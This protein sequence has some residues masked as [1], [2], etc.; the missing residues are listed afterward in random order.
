[1]R[2]MMSWPGTSAGC[3]RPG[4]DEQRRTLRMGDDAVQPFEVLEQ[5]ARALVR[6]EAA[7]EADREDVGILR[8]RVAQHAIEM[9]LA[10]AIAQV[11]VPDASAHHVEHPALE[12]A[13]HGPEQVVGNA[14]D[15]RERAAVGEMLGP[16]RTDEAL[17]QVGPLGRHERAVV[18]RVR[19]VIDRILG[20]RHLRPQ[21]LQHR[22][23]NAAVN[24]GHAVVEARSAY[25]ER[26][27]V[28]V[29]RP[30]H[31]AERQQALRGNVMAPA[32]VREVRRDGLVAEVVVSC[33][34]R[35]VRGEERVRCDRFERCVEVE[36]L[37]H[38]HPDALDDQERGVTF[39]DV[40]HGGRDA[41][42][43][44]DARTADAE[45][46][47][48]LEADVVVAAVESMRDAAVAV[49]VLGQIGVEEVELHVPDSDVPYA[50][51]ERA[52]GE[53]DADAQLA[54]IGQAH[55]VHGEVGEV[56]IGVRRDLVAFGVELLLEV[57]LAVQQSDA[58]ERK[59][60]VARRL[61]VIAGEDAE[62]PG[63]D[64]Q[65]FVEAELRA[66]VRHEI[67]RAEGR[68]ARAQR[69]RRDVRVE[70]GQHA[71]EVAH[72][73]LVLRNGEQAPLVD[74]A[75]EGARALAAVLPQLDVHAPEELARGAIPAVP[76]VRGELGEPRELRRDVRMDFDEIRCSGQRHRGISSEAV[77]FSRDAVPVTRSNYSE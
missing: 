15:L 76:Q 6:R 9:R 46:D 62:A 13:V 44:E 31:L 7:A 35:R 68:H 20:S 29:V 73:V 54:A 72:E 14:V 55:R 40:P 67:V 48:L 26:G 65:A 52:S 19:D 45:H 33:G 77:S 58:D 30:R 63:V 60:Q 57:A 18:H 39:V 12:I 53:R 27:H 59:A 3:A 10:A 24:R 23:R 43:F 38:Q 74:P 64:R 70:R 8:I 47:L 21:R 22:R 37:A 49:A 2:R 66:E 11:L 42:R 1:M 4:E 61:A 36:A 34:H 25:R 5:Q 56:G 41:H 51:G 75:Q 17:E 32:E 69:L 50:H 71:P 16:A 28:E